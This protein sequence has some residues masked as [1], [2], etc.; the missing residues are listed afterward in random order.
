MS[1]VSIMYIFNYVLGNNIPHIA[2]FTD[3]IPSNT[4]FVSSECDTLICSDLSDNQV[5][6]SELE[7][8]SDRDNH[9]LSS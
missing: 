4:V 1:T 2:S 3:A 5:H 8:K 9:I 6:E 7:S